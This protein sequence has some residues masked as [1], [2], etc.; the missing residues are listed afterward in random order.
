MRHTKQIGLLGPALECALPARI[1]GT[2]Q[3]GGP[4][5]PAICPHCYIG[6]PAWTLDTAMGHCRMCGATW[7]LTVY[8]YTPPPPRRYAIPRHRLPNMKGA[9]D[10]HR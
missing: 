3:R 5:M 9:P 7:F 4:I 6:P 10:G 1:E 2:Q 8:S